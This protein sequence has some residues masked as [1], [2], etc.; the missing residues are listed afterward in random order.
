MAVFSCIG[1][2][3]GGVVAVADFWRLPNPRL[4]LTS[5]GGVV[6]LAAGVGGGGAVGH[7]GAAV[8]CVA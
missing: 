1:G 3:I 2:G 4:H 5:F 8:A 7:M 6:T